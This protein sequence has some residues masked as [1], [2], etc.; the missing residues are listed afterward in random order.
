M[1]GLRI[2]GNIKIKRIRHLSSHI[3]F[4][5]LSKAT[6]FLHRLDEFLLH[7]GCK[8]VIRQNIQADQSIGLARSQG[9]CMRVL[10]SCSFAKEYGM[11]R[12]LG[13]YIKNC[14]DAWANVAAA[15]KITMQKTNTFVLVLMANPVDANCR[16]TQHPALRKEGK[17]R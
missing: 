12:I 10:G 7:L 6:S 16:G 14:L 9:F 8:F 5:S 13:S 1:T 4:S 2:W 3:F 11:W 15:S 17:R